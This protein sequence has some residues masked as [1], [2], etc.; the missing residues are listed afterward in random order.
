MNERG[1]VLARI[2]EATKAFST[3]LSHQPDLTVA[4][5]NLRLALA[6]KGR[7]TDAIAG[8]ARKQLPQVL[9]NIGYVAMVLGDFE[10]ADVFFNRAIDESPIYYDT[11]Q[12]NLERLQSLVDKP[13]DQRP[14]RGVGR[15][16][17]N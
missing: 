16:L 11:A 4:R 13:A 2:D 17:G 6:A 8:T 7:Y 12:E 1:V 10:S 15:S 5:A 9:N 3:S 14:V